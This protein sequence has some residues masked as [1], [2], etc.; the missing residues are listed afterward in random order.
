MSHRTTPTLAIYGPITRS[1][2]PGLYR[3]ACALLRRHAP[4]LMVCEVWGVEPDAVAVDALAQLAL[5]ARRQ[6]CQIR[7]RGGSAEL[8]ELVSFM[9]LAEVFLD[10]LADSA[11]R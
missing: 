10:P 6:G 4:A 5:A 8:R 2:L 7:L 11:S 1:D 9:G 3:R